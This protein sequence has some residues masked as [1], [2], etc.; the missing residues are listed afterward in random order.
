MPRF[1][2]S[3]SQKN[4]D[5]LVAIAEKRGIKIQQLLYASVIPE[6]LARLEK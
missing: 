1:M 5:K 3:L 4:Y 6:W 2:L